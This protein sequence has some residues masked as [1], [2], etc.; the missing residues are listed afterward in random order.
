MS[1]IGLLAATS[2][3]VDPTPS[4]EVQNL[5]ITDTTVLSSTR[6][7]LYAAWDPIPG[8][9]YAARQTSR[10]TFATTAWVDRGEASTAVFGYVSTFSEIWI[11]VATYTEAGSPAAPDGPVTRLIFWTDLPLPPQTVGGPDSFDLP[12]LLPSGEQPADYAMPTTAPYSVPK[13]ARIPTYDGSG[14]ALHPS[15]IDMV[16]ETGSD[17][18]GFRY[19]M[20]MTPHYLS[21]DTLEN[22]SVVV[23][24]HGW[25][26]QVPD[27]LTNPLD[28]ADERHQGP[29]SGY[30]NS[31][32]ELAWDPEGGRFIL[33]WRRAYEKLHAAESVDGIHW[34]Y[35]W[36]ILRDKADYLVSPCIVRTGPSQWRMWAGSLVGRMSMWESASPLGRMEGSPWEQVAGPLTNTPIGLRNVDGS[37]VTDLWHYAIK[38]DPMTGAF[39]LLG[40]KRDGNMYAAVSLDGIEWTFGPSLLSGSYRPTMVQSDDPDWW[41]VWNSHT[42]PH[43]VTGETTNW[44]YYT[45]VPRS[46]WTNLL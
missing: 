45:R 34:R 43:D 20:G 14:S 2:A 42:R 35:H 24:N 4:G 16:A 21:N 32:T 40:S 22:P 8:A 41:H 11:E 37:P 39:F 18:R 25:Q 38:Q 27:G 17:F 3:P 15:V 44:I 28:Y 36:F 7:N 30:F 13:V 33:Y 19:W 29:D 46:A 6:V 10:H 26:W 5:R 12:D 23:S 9:R 1:L 31:D